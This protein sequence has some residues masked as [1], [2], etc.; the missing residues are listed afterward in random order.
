MELAALL[1]SLPEGPGWA[2]AG[3]VVAV[4]FSPTGLLSKKMAEENLGGLSAAA[5]WWQN[6]KA[7][8]IERDRQVES[9]ELQAVNDR[10]DRLSAM[11]DDDRARWEKTERT[12]R[13]T[14][15][16]LS[17]YLV[18]VTRWAQQLT[19]QA[20]HEGWEIPTLVPYDEWLQLRGAQ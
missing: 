10:L 18:F 6:R 1:K 9:A 8:A 20:A 17:D 3:I 12:L 2:I 13:E 15:H 19:I 7:R 14:N 4:I 11:Y 16:Q 5:R